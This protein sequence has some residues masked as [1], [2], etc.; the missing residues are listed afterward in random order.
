MTWRVPYTNRWLRERPRGEGIDASRIDF[1]PFSDLEQSV[2]ASVER[3][4]ESPLLPDRF[5][6]SGYVYDVRN[7]E[8]LA[9]AGAEAA[10][11]R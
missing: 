1:L 9:V 5:G 10:V 8:L 7:G 11:P 4:R 3:I 6:A 2:R